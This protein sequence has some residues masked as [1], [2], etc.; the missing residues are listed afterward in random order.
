MSTY[1]T[2][3]VILR[4]SDFGEAN[5]LLRIFTRD[6][7][8]IEAVGRSARKAKGKLKGHLEPFLYSDFVL[9]RGK[10][11]DTVANSF[12]I[13]AFLNLRS[14]MET[15][16]LTSAVLE[17]ADRMTMENY[18][19]EKMFNLVLETMN[20]FD[21]TSLSREKMRLTL[22]FFEINAL[23]L[24]GF[25]PRSKNCVFCSGEIKPGKSF[26]SFSLGGVLDDKCAR[27]CPDALAV[28][29]DTIKL[30]RF[31]AVSDKSEGRENY[32]S[33]VE[34]KLEEAR[35]LNVNGDIV[36]RGAFLMKNF[37]EFNIDQRINSLKVL[38][39]VTK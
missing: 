27:K 20:F 16:I 15:A 35:K 26:F 18:R 2:E 6:F 34:E 30:L 1:R 19:D 13:K 4:R 29:D 8:K 22:L 11:M 12:V 17:I 25:A 5:L 38:C 31:L 3:G 36:L 10:K 32:I 24:S 37:I 23:A 7:G 14:D 33:A 9:A 28:D 21:E 39:D